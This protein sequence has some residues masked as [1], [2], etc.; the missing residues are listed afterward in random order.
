MVDAKV[1]ALLHIRVIVNQ[2]VSV[3]RTVQVEEIGEFD[4]CPMVYRCIALLFFKI[5]A[6]MF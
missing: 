6:H 2:R 1:V 3:N 4:F 5:S